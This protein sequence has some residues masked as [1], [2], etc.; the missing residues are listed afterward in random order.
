MRDGR[1][2]GL[3]RLLQLIQEPVQ[4]IAEC[5]GY[6]FICLIVARPCLPTWVS[7]PQDKHLM[8]LSIVVI[9]HQ[10]QASE[11]LC[12]QWP[13]KTLSHEVAGLLGG[14]D[15]TRTPSSTREVCKVI[16]GAAVYRLPCM[17]A[18]QHPGT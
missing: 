7:M 6:T 4:Q 3:D 10:K 15:D 5:S 17:K 13:W 11:R 2:L 16:P 18:P 1:D 14:A 8:C 12:L 9:W